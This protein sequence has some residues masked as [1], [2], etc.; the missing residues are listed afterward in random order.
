MLTL[1]AEDCFF[2]HIYLMRLSA[3][4]VPVTN[5]WEGK[6]EVNF[7]VMENSCGRFCRYH[8]GAIPNTI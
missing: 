3:L 6:L 7:K 1:D 8:V 5:E 4:Y 2:M